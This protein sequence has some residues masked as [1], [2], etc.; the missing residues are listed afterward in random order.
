MR[1]SA[2]AR[3]WSPIDDRDGRRHDWLGDEDFHYHDLLSS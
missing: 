2:R 3:L 1:T